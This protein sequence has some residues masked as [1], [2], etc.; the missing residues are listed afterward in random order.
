MQLNLLHAATFHTYWI[1]CKVECYFCIQFGFHVNLLKI[2]V[3]QLFGYRLTLNFLD[4][5]V[6]FARV[7]QFQC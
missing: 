6:L 3:Q 5:H 2:N 1:T 4:D 7:W